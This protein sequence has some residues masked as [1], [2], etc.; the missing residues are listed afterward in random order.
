M[1]QTG[2]VIKSMGKWYNVLLEDGRTIS[3]RIRGK[4]RLEGVKTT[5]PIAVGDEVEL[6]LLEKEDG[7]VIHSIHQ[8]K[9][10]LVRKSVNLSKRSHILAANIDR[11]YLLVTLVAPITH[12]AFIDRFLVAAESFRI[13]VTLLFNKM[14][15]YFEDHLPLVDEIAAIYENIGY[16]CYKISALNKENIEFLRD[17]INRKQV[18]ISGH[19]GTGKSTLINALDNNLTIKTSEISSHHLQGQHTTT[20]AEMHP[21]KSGGFIIDTPGIKAFGIIDLEKE[22]ISHYFPE[23]RELLNKCRFHNCLHLNEP[24][25]AVKDAAE[26]GE[27]ASSRYSTYLDL[28]QEDEKENYRKAIFG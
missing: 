8:R 24:S 4:V 6:E 10:Y 7:G 14:D 16:P 27:I 19:S 25:C 11:A 23:M 26:N 3:C 2:R 21:L 13:P 28:I 12:L 5:N 15:L 9:N 22:V 17:E 18:M 1:L 20:F